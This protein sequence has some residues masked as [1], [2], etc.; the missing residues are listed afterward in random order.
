MLYRDRLDYRYGSTYDIPLEEASVDMVWSNGVIHLTLDYEGS[1]R[2]FARV[3]KPGGTLF[4]CVNGRFGL[5]ELLFDTLRVTSRDIPPELFQHFLARLG[6]NTGRIYW[7]MC[8]LYGPYQWKARA[9]VEALLVKHGFTEL[10]QLT[11]GLEI[12][13]IEQVTTGLP[14]AELK[15][16]E[17]QLRYLARKA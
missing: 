7:M 8:A 5:F 12:D 13:H 2:E 17:A 3:L 1:I 10:R 15:Y 14:Y 4:L 11:R 6:I 9:E 16:G